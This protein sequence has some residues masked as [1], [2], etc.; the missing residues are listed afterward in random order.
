MD[1]PAGITS[2]TKGF[3]RELG[4][5]DFR[6]YVRYSFGDGFWLV[7]CPIKD[8]FGFREETK[9]RY[10]LLNDKALDDM[11]RR[12][13]IGLKLNGDMNEYIKW[14]KSEQVAEG[15]RLE[16]EAIDMQVEGYMRIHAWETDTR[17]HYFT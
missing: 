1:L 7:I 5:I 10:H 6:Y 15:E 12:K 14:M 3:L 9:G 8:R 13:R 17:P 11:R 2:P 4:F 16:R